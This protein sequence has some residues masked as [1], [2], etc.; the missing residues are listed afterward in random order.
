L[1]Y[2]KFPG[3]NSSGLFNANRQVKDSLTLTVIPVCIREK[4]WTNSES[5]P[6]KYQA[7]IL[8]KQHGNQPVEMVDGT[9]VWANYLPP[10]DNPGNLQ[11]KITA[12]S[13][14]HITNIQQLLLTNP[15]LVGAAP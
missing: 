5:A 9:P 8:D 15:G 11:D 14:A 6:Y 12:V 10:C 3:G 4:Y 1:S 13:K 2:L 7:R